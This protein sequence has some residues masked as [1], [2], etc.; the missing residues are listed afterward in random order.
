MSNPPGAMRTVNSYIYKMDIK[1]FVPGAG[2]MFGERCS[3]VPRARRAQ[4][5]WP[6]YTALIISSLHSYSIGPTKQQSGDL[7]LTPKMSSSSL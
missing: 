4:L 3:L 6:W 1:R 5:V 7:H 2:L